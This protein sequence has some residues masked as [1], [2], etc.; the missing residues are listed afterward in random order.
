MK[1]DEHLWDA[2]QAHGLSEAHLDML[3]RA[4]DLQRNGSLAWHFAHGQLCKCDLHLT[5]ASRQRDV[6]HISEGMLAEGKSLLR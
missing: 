6:D 5:F 3:L 4:L 1:L 2:L